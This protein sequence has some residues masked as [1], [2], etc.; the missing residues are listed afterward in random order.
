MVEM[1]TPILEREVT[2]IRL[3]LARRGRL[4]LQVRH[5]MEKVPLFGDPKTIG[6]GP[7][8]D[9]DSRKPDELAQAIRLMPPNARNQR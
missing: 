3:R 1:L 5:R 4:V 7:W 8:R 2:S 6:H 9:A